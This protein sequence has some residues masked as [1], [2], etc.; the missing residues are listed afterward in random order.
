VF[1]VENIGFFA[2]RILPDC[3]TWLS[4]IIYYSGSF[5]ADIWWLWT[6]G[7]SFTFRLYERIIRY[8]R[9]TTSWIL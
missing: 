4:F 3:P 5:G 2:Q 9:L 7:V 1:T 8:S 6:K